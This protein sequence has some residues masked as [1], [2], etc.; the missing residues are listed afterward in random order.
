[1]LKTVYTSTG[2]AEYDASGNYWGTTSQKLMKL[3]CMDADIDVSLC[4]IIQVPFLTPD[5]DMSGIYPFVMEIYLTDQS[6][7]RITSSAVDCQ[8]TVHIIYNRDMLHTID[9]ELAFG[10]YYPYADFKVRG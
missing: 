4:D 5:D 2:H 8:V 3:Q 10:G 9:P 6:G 7:E 1:M